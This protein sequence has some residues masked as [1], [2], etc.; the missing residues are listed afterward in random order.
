MKMLITFEPHGIFE[1]NLHTYAC[2]HSLITGMRKSLFY[3]RRFAEHQSSRLWSVS[4]F[5]HNVHNS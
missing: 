4:E 3:G 1:S 2:Q 5:V